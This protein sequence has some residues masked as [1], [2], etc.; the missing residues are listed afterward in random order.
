MAAEVATDLGRY[1]VVQAIESNMF[2]YWLSLGGGDRGEIHDGPDLKWVYTG[3]PALNR[4]F[5]ARLDEAQVDARVADVVARFG[6]WRAGVA[7]LVGPS[8]RPAGL[9]RRLAAHGFADAG[10]WTGMAFDLARAS[11]SDARPGGPPGLVVREVADRQ[12]CR[13]WL[14]IVGASFRLPGGAI[15][16][17]DRVAARLG[18]GDRAPWRRYVGFLD[19]RPV[20][21]ATLFTEAGVAGVYL[22]ATVPGARRRGLGS[23]LTRHVVAEARASGHRLVVL[24]ATQ[25]GRELYRKIGFEAYCQIGVYRWAPAG[26]AGTLQRWAG[27][28]DALWRYRL[29]GLAEAGTWGRRPG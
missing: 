9:V 26:G 20:S 2:A 29:G 25:A 21:T 5:G 12:T 6:A 17:F 16:T 8:T 10:S 13:S 22:V 4:V 14:Q 1:A 19:G 27:R 18:F 28:L 15:D 11:C 23:V 7:W 3:G 24:Q